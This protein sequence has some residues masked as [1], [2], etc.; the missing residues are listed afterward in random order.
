M[1]SSPNKAS[2][3]LLR[4]LAQ[5]I[6]VWQ[7]GLRRGPGDVDDDTLAAYIAGDL[8]PAEAKELEARLAES[9][10][11]EEVVRLVREAL[12]ERDWEAEPPK[13]QLTVHPALLVA[14]APP[15][16]HRPTARRRSPIFVWGMGIAALAACLVAAVVVLDP[17]AA[18]NDAPSDGQ[19][20]VYRCTQDDSGLVIDREALGPGEALQSGDAFQIEIAPTG[21]ARFCLLHIDPAGHLRTLHDGVGAARGQGAPLV[22]PNAEQAYR[23]DD[24]S[25]LEGL[26]LVETDAPQKLLAQAEEAMSGMLSRSVV[27]GHQRRL[28][29]AELDEFVRELKDTF[30]V[31]DFVVVEHKPQ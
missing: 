9:S 6:R 23:L 3:G 29:Q 27:R 5:E 24:A 26:V 10:E 4:R 21:V 1:G 30:D 7:E 25:G 13:S 31:R 15:D 11:L 16:S 28:A 8:P 14:A 22:L 12:A 2:A 20:L 18:T 17:F 19:L